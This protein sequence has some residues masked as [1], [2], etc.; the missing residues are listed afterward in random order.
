[1]TLYIGTPN[2]C[3]APFL[4]F[5][6]GR[7]VRKEKRWGSILTIFLLLGEFACIVVAIALPIRNWEATMWD[8]SPLA[9]TV[10]YASLTILS[11]MAT[12][13]MT[14]VCTSNFGKGLEPYLRRNQVTAADRGSI[15]S[16]K[17]ANGFGDGFEYQ[18]LSQPAPVRMEID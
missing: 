12:V 8:K 2:L 9:C 13:V 7:F 5:F 10:A 17:R 3:A 6:A 4:L 16:N 1:M 14:M 18:E 15:E 11:L